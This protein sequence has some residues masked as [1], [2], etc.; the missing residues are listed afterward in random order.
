[1]VKTF[2]T[3]DLK[4][5]RALTIQQAAFYANTSRDI[6]LRWLNSG[7]LGYYILPGTSSKKIQRRILREELDQFLEAQYRKSQPR[8]SD[9]TGGNKYHQSSKLELLPKEK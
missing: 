4:R 8:Q 2:D 7:M 1:M 3:E 6:V 9:I 5:Q